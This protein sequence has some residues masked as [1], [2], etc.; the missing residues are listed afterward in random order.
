MQS[1]LLIQ[2]GKDKK[3]AVPNAV[4]GDASQELQAASPC[5]AAPVT[6]AAIPGD[7]LQ[8][9]SSSAF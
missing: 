8:L 2:S 5:R 6:P 4:V 1:C 3:D 7:G 9:L